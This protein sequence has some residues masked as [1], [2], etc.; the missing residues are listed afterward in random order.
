M[1]RL[2]FF[3]QQAETC[4]RL[5]E[6]CSDES[7]ADQLRLMGAEFFRKATELENDWLAAPPADPARARLH[8]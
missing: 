3:R 4:F 7:T 5:A 8:R 2:R 1:S 6:Q